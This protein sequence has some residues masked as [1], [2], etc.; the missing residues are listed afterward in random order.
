MRAEKQK[1]FNYFNLIL[2]DI[3]NLIDFFVDISDHELVDL[4]MLT[5]VI[6]K[7]EQLRSEAGRKMVSAISKDEG[8]NSQFKLS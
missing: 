3:V 5:E 1:V 7:F 4:S 8:L 2:N 6:S